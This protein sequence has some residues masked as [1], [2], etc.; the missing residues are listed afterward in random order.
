MNN[1]LMLPITEVS[2]LAASVAKSGMISGI[3]TPEQ[4]FTLMMI[5]QADGLHPMKALQRY[6]IIEGRPSWKSGALLAAFIERGGKVCF[7]ER[8][9]ERVEA[10]FQSADGDTITVEWTYEM[11]E[12]AGL[13]GKKNWKYPRQML[14]ARVISEGV[15]VADPG[16]AGGFYTSEETIDIIEQEK[17]EGNFTPVKK[18][19]RSSKKELDPLAGIIQAS[20]VQV[21][22]EPEEHPQ[23]QEILDI[24]ES[25]ENAE[26]VDNAVKITYKMIIHGMDQ[27]TKDIVQKAYVDK[28]KALIFSNVPGNNVTEESSEQVLAQLAG[29]VDAA[30]NREELAGHVQK[31]VENALDNMLPNHQEKLRDIIKLRVALFEDE[32]NKAKKEEITEISLKKEMEN[33]IPDPAEVANSDKVEAELLAEINSK[34]TRAALKP[35]LKVIFDRKKELKFSAYERLSKVF[36]EKS[37]ELES[38]IPKTTAPGK[39]SDN[40]AEKAKNNADNMAWMKK[41]TE[42]AISALPGGRPYLQSVLDSEPYIDED[43][44]QYC[45]KVVNVSVGVPVGCIQKVEVK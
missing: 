8:T 45:C 3:N 9:S 13:T 7:H 34:T 23:L 4:A 17:E 36:S 26:D 31:A 37:H 19:R 30:K 39:P 1:Q 18:S 11:A 24:I 22:K 32:E 5:C 44:K 41:G 15:G 42:A 40:A 27:P 21:Q 6:H 28:R 35:M 16:I 33:K 43:T 38:K 14:T 29:Q 20:E 12:A 25:A 2:T 10:T